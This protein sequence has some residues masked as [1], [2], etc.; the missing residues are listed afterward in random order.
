MG[1]KI[2]EE[3]G[4]LKQVKAMISLPVFHAL[5]MISDTPGRSHSDVIKTALFDYIFKNYPNLIKKTDMEIR[6][7][8]E[9]EVLLGE[10]TRKFSDKR[11]ADEFV[12]QYEQAQ[13]KLEDKIDELQKKFNTK[14]QKLKEKSISE[15]EK[16]KLLDEKE[17]LGFQ[18]SGCKNEKN[19]NED[20]LERL[21]KNQKF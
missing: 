7:Q 8:A 9:E 17:E 14:N 16:Q 3:S 20:H 4:P 6:I 15:K 2:S 12:P 5:E 21:K 1:K 10:Y 19:I 13:K 18:L 11:Q